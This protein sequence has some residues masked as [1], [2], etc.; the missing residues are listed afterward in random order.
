MTL[1]VGAL[2]SGYG[3]L[4]LALGDVLPV[5]LAWYAELDT[6]ASKIMARHWPGV[7]NHGDVTTINWANVEPVDVITGGSPCQDISNAGK[8]AGMRPGT[9]SGLWESMREAVAVIRPGLVVWENVGAVLSASAHSDVEC[10]AG[11]VGDGTGE[12]PLR[13]LG[14]V[15]GD[16]AS[17]G[18]DAWWT[19]VR[20]SDVGAP[21]QRLRVFLFA[22]PSD[23]PLAAWRG[24][25]LEHLGSAPGPTAELGEPNSAT[26]L[27]LLPTPAVNDMGAAYTPDEWDAW[28]ERMRAKHGNGN[29][30]GKSL[31]VEAQRLLPTP[32]T[33][34]TN[35]PGAHG[36][37]GPDLRTVAA[38]LPTPRATRGGSQ[39]ETA[40][41]LGGERTDDHRPQGQVL[42]AGSR[43]GEYAAAVAR[44]E[45]ALGRPAPDPT[46]PAPKGGR[47]LNPALT[48][49]LMGLPDGWVTETP[50]ITHNDM[51]RACGNGV[52]RQQAAAALR[53]YLTNN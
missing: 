50:G 14:R 45:Q 15:C 13:A 10:D 51:L 7:P 37:G 39:T 52:V 32:R 34:D 42:L 48:E 46:V 22:T 25:Q 18:Y 19:S 40:Y 49:W 9:R 16:L 3:G 41:A 2:F 24:P 35:G 1:K 27:T 36:D 31:N 53:D 26:P 29:G 4:E 21:H 5:D 47:R 6:A 30:H 38:L 20:A 8:R 17:V 28:T 33:S 23:A 44:W 11:C 43:W 12:P